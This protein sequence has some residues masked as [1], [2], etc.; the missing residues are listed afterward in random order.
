MD[1]L[2]GDNEGEVQE[3]L[4]R[5]A[6]AINDGEDDGEAPL[7]LAFCRKFSP[8]LDWELFTGFDRETAQLIV[9]RAV[10]HTIRSRRS[11]IGGRECVIL[12]LVWFRG[13]SNV[14]TIASH[15]CL[16]Y[17]QCLRGLQCEIRALAT[18]FEPFEAYGGAPVLRA[19]LGEDER[20]TIPERAQQSRFIVDGKHIEGKRIGTFEDASTYYSYKLGG[21]AYQFQCVVT[22]LGQCVHVSEAER[23]ATHDMMVYRRNRVQLLAG[24]LAK[25]FRDPII[26]ADQGYKCELPE[27]FVP[28]K[29]N[30]APNG[31]R[32]VVENYFG[33]M[34]N[35]FRVVR[36]RFPF[37]YELVNPFLRALCFLTNIN[38]LKRPLRRNEYML[39]R[40]FME[41]RRRKHEERRARKQPAPL[42][43]D[44]SSDAT[45]DETLT[46]L[47]SHSGSNWSPLSS[48]ET[49]AAK[50]MPTLD[51][52]GG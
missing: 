39:H 7:P 5:G 20:D 36:M 16:P 21:L 25:G 26:I 35:V 1:P 43:P 46:Q 2:F 34:T 30:K 9:E 40:A 32:L 3:I 28:D 52:R 44:N 33:R 12:A 48:F 14:K 18:C 38:V 37:G 4:E 11:E 47:L 29:P 10:P 23:A 42:P 50:K 8:T 24:L 19:L 49:P 6:S 17:Q 45:Q 31:R 22:H 41:C 27:L 51:E 13:G 15:A